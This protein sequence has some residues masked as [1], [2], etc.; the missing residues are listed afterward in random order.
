M[1]TVDKANFV[2]STNNTNIKEPLI[3][4]SNWNAYNT[5]Y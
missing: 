2:E 3:T 1:F 4:V 5:P